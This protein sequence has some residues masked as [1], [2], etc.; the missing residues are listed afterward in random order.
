[1]EFLFVRWFGCDLSPKPGWRAKR[2][3]Q[4]GFVPGNGPDAFGFI[5]PAQV[6]RS[7]H[8]IPAFA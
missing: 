3:I 6:I 1:M 5:D 4:L 8:L 2:L 7:L